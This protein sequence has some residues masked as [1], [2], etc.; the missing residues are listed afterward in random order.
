MK[1]LLLLLLLMLPMMVCAQ[2]DAKK[3]YIY[4]IFSFSGNIKNEGLTLRVDNGVSI[5]KLKDDKGKK[6]VFRTPAAALMY[7]ISQG[8][9]MYMSGSTI[10]GD[11]AMGYGSTDTSSYWIMRKECSKDVFEHAINVG[12]N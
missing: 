3:Y 9:E 4:N 5:E 11:S 8:W 10:E 6:V 7:L 1:K 12:R 2:E